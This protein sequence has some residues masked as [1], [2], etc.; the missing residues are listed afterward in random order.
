[1]SEQPH[2]VAM[3]SAPAWSDQAAPASARDQ[4]LILWSHKWFIVCVTAAMTLVAGVASWLMPEKFQATVVI[5]PVSEDY[6]SGRLAG[7][8]AVLSQVGGL[9]SLA[10]ISTTASSIREESIATLQSS[11]LTQDFIETNGLLPV[12]FADK[13]DSS[14]NRWRVDDGSKAPTLWKANDFFRKHVRTVVEDRKTGLLTLTITWKDPVLAAR[15]ANDLVKMANDYLRSK[16]IR[17]SERNIAYLNEQVSKTNIVEVKKAIFSLMEAEIRK[18]MIARGADEYALKVI[19][20]ALVPERPSSPRR[21]LWIGAGFF[22]GLL[23]AVTLILS[24][25]ML[26][27]AR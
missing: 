18:V 10:G 21:V 16:A 1:M 20:R 3:T 14:R 25:Q 5:S 2:R 15:W 12:L 9:A 13:W 7:I 22:G 27:S 4:L 24:R 11:S 17:E 23:V 19:D 6:S 8:G 26:R